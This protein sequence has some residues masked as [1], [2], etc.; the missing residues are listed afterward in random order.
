MRFSELSS[1]LERLEKTAS[2]NQMTEILAEFLGKL[3]VDEVD[4]ACYL[5]LGRLG[6]LY[7]TVEFNLAEKMMIRVLAEAFGVDDKEAWQRYKGTGDLG[8]VAEQLRVSFGRSELRGGLSVEEVFAKLLEIAGAEGTGSQEVKVLKM[9]ELLRSLG[10]LSNRY[11]TRIPLGQLRLGFSDVTLIDALSWVFKG[12]K[13]VSDEIR[14]KFNICP[15]IGLLAVKL[16]RKGLR[17]LKEVELAVGHPIRSALAE[18]LPSAE[19]I[20]EKLGKFA[21]EPKVDGLRVQIHL[22]KSSKFKAQSSKSD[23]QN[24]LFGKES[25]ID[26]DVLV[27]IFSRNMAD[28]THMFPEIVVAAQKL[29]VESAILDGEAI[30]FNPDTEEFLPFQETMQRK[31]KY[32]VVEKSKKIPLK[33][34]VF[35]ILFLNGRSLL[36]ESFVERRKGLEGVVRGGVIELI[37]HQVVSSQDK[38]RELFDL[39]ISEGLEGV[40]C[41][42]LDTPYQAGARNFDWIKYKRGT[43]GKGLP[44][45]VDGLVL[46]YYAGRG[47]RA[48]LGVGAFLVGVYNSDS[49]I[50]ETVAKVGTGLTD[51]QWEEFMKRVKGLQVKDRPKQYLIDKALTCDFWV[52][53]G[54]VVEID[55]DEITRS[56]VHTAGRD[57]EVEEVRDSGMSLRFPRLVCFRE[58][59]LEEVTT[60]K[61][62]LAM[63]RMQKK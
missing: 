54:L 30:A 49:D 58:K 22:S 48:K 56:P 23:N 32:R 20:V 14:A 25:G 39:Y 16:R 28:S 15:D 43:E 61:E 31:R 51:S 35:D 26:P 13:S 41:K 34:F 60:A 40:M 12:D 52:R 29:P 42:K 55:A 24:D 46:G 57:L 7:E 18:R 8:V 3:S 36:D 53:P 17:D 11:V 2:R 1:Y 33:V 62:I 45:T 6:P 38:L 59:Q 4:K 47:Q 21:V 37:R 10:S 5:V 19:K 9:A 44:D 50:F 27:R 63:Y